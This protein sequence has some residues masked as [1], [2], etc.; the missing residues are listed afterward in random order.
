MVVDE[1]KYGQL[2]KLNYLEGFSDT[3]S[4]ETV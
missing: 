3:R 2:E 4:N 1:E